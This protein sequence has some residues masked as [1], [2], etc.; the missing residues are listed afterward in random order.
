MNSWTAC[1]MTNH[2]YWV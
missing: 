2:N 1:K